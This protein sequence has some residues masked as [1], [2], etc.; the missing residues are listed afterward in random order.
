V[1]NGAANSPNRIKVPATSKIEFSI[2]RRHRVDP[3]WR[4]WDIAKKLEEQMSRSTS[5]RDQSIKITVHFER[6]DDGGLRIWSDDLPGLNLSHRDPAL[7]L[8]DVKFALEG[9]ITDMLGE[10]VSVEPLVGIREALF[11]KTNDAQQVPTGIREYVSRPI[12][13]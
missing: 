9:L 5:Y 13:A 11:P 3:D 4:W 2:R 8:D 7:A 1:R 10:R 6:R 12:A